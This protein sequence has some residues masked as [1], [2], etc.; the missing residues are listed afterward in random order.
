MWVEK[1]SSGTKNPHFDPFQTYGRCTTTSSPQLLVTTNTNSPKQISTAPFAGREPP[2]PCHLG[3]R[4]SKKAEWITSA[5]A[6][7][8][9]MAGNEVAA[10]APVEGV[11]VNKT[12]AEEEVKEVEIT[13]VI[14]HQKNARGVI[15]GVAVVMTATVSRHLYHRHH[16]H[17][18]GAPGESI[19]Q[20]RNTAK[21]RR[22][23]TKRRR[24]ESTKRRKRVTG[25]VEADHHPI[26]HQ[27]QK[28]RRHRELM[29]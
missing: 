6:T 23:N 22:K 15:I 26:L 10:G 18:Q 7:V 27:Q 21:T 13:L 12:V 2:L 28:P 25:V 8:I 19:I 11:I 20:K 3:N 16:L 9:V 17:P 29:N 24:T 1:D 5:A 14:T 4:E